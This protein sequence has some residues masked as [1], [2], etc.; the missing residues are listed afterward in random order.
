M[1][2]RGCRDT[3]KGGK[4]KDW[5]VGLLLGEGEGAKNGSQSEQDWYNNFFRSDTIIFLCLVLIALHFHVGKLWQNVAIDA[6]YTFK[7]VKENENQ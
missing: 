1:K 3:E 4:E 5:G 6:E 7:L 2:P